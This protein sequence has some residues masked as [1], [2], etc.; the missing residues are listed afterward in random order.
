MSAEGASTKKY[1]KKTN[2]INRSL[3]KSKLFCLT[4]LPQ[5]GTEGLYFEDKSLKLKI[6]S[7]KKLEMDFKSRLP[8]GRGYIL[9]DKV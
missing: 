5:N 7:L 3:F 9:I 8:E 2:I 1:N 4:R 6:L